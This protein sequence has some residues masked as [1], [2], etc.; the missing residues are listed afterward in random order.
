MKPSTQQGEWTEIVLVKFDANALS[1]TGLTQLFLTTSPQLLRRS[2]TDTG[3]PQQHFS[4]RAAAFYS[5]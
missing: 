4:S 1:K 3:K 5:N 2:T